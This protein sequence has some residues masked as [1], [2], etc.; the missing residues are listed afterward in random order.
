LNKIVT[1]ASPSARIEAALHALENKDSVLAGSFL[2]LA[3][4]KKDS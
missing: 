4:A 1:T 2:V 3:T